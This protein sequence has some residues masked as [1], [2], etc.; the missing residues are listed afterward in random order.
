MR[1][2]DWCARVKNQHWTKWMWKRMNVSAANEWTNERKKIDK[3]LLECARR[4]EFE[5]SQFVWTVTL[6][7]R[8]RQAG[9]CWL[10]TVLLLMLPYYCHVNKKSSAFHSIIVIFS[11]LASNFKA[12][13]FFCRYFEKKRPSK[14]NLPSTP[15]KVGL[16]HVRHIFFGLFLTFL[17][18]FR[19]L[20][21]VVLSFFH[22]VRIFFPIAASF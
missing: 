5:F 12:P 18:A 14:E 10:C 16:V 9:N 17:Y 4:K 11:V 7:G 21:F 13:P 3:S 19:S 20:S 22:Y 8:G 1:I 15:G 2:D 6:T